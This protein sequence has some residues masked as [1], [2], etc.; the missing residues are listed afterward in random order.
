MIST[1]ENEVVEGKSHTGRN[2]LIHDRNTQ[3]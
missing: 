1:V 2:V 3:K